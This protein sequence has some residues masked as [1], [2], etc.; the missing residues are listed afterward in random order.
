MLLSGVQNNKMSRATTSLQELGFDLA[1]V[2][3]V[4]VLSAKAS[5]AEL[6][7]LLQRMEAKCP[8]V[9]FSSK[10]V[11]A[12]ATFL[13]RVDAQ[14]Q[15]LE[16]KLTKWEKREHD[17]AALKPFDDMFARVY[18]EMKVFLS[19]AHTHTLLLLLLLCFFTC[20]LVQINE[21]LENNA[22]APRPRKRARRDD[23]DLPNIDY[24][25]GSA[26]PAPSAASSVGSLPARMSAA[27]V[28]GQPPLEEQGS[29]EIFVRVPD[30]STQTARID[31]ATTAAD[32]F[33]EGDYYATF[34]GREL[35]DAEPLSNQGVV[36]GSTLHYHERVRGGALDDDRVPT[37]AE[38][39]LPADEVFFSLSLS[40]SFFI[41]IFILICSNCVVLC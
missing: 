38:L 10:S 5:Q 26:S 6:D 41:F 36:A 33:E 28:E 22:T 32:L 16:A 14:R 40:L 12:R 25:L 8:G 23:S 19:L 35:E 1:A 31:T 4:P 29:V 21:A 2:E 3:S 20:L 11:I 17:C 13:S 27:R 39:G 18:N 15:R 34:R 37:R 30:G 9:D 7:E 24:G